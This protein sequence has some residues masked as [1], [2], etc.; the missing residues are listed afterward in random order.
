MN[1]H[2]PTSV[3]KRILVLVLAAGAFAFSACGTDDP[4]PEGA[5][6]VGDSGYWD[7]SLYPRPAEPAEPGVRRPH[8]DE[9]VRA[10]RAMGGEPAVPTV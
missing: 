10:P 9:S 7:G 3:T 1:N 8:D 5:P 6:P 4:S 2:A